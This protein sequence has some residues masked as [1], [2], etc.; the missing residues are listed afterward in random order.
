M[1]DPHLVEFPTAAVLPNGG[2]ALPRRGLC[3]RPSRA[4]LWISQSLAPSYRAE[5]DAGLL[6]AA[7]NAAPTGAASSRDPSSSI[8]HEGAGVPNSPRRLALPRRSRSGA[9]ARP[10]LPHSRS[11]R[12]APAAAAAPPPPRQ[13]AS[14]PKKRKKQLLRGD[15]IDPS[16]RCRCRRWREG[17][18][19]R[20]REE[21]AA[22]G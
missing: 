8:F 10:A 19:G 9:G 16:W 13:R 22:V 20:G 7:A 21:L 3:R 17:M 18:Q 12:R 11:P 1:G 6:L 15:K 2:D 4:T 5:A 14:G